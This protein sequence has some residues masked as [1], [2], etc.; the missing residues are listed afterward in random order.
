MIVVLDSNAVIAHGRAFPERVREAAADGTDL[1]LPR[2]VER[3]LVDDVLANDDAPEGHKDS[4]RTIRAL[5]EEG[6]LTVRRPDFEESG[7]VV[8]E[9]RRRIADDSL[10]EHAVQADQY[11]PAIVC[12]LAIEGNVTLVTADRKLE[13]IVREFAERRAV[14]GSVSVRKPRT[15]LPAGDPHG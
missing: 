8:D 9:A 1:V 11:L 4:A 3:E 12:E 5:V 10:P 14:A 2:S 15:V 7:D 6:H 13:R